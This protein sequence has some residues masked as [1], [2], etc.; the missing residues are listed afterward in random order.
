MGGWWWWVTQSEGLTWLFE[1]SFSSQLIFA[2][3]MIGYTGTGLNTVQTTRGHQISII[4]SSG[5]G[6]AGRG[7]NYSSLFSALTSSH[8][9]A[10]FIS[11]IIFIIG[12]GHS[13]WPE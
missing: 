9:L 13:G 5:G 3:R 11:F 6:A 1:Q 12:P 8:H 4:R 2:V 10:I 7:D